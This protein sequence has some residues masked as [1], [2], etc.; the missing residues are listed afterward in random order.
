MVKFNKIEHFRGYR[1]QIIYQQWFRLFAVP[2]PLWRMRCRC[3]PAAHQQYILYGAI[4]YAI[5]KN[6][7][8]IIITS[9]IIHSFY[10]WQNIFT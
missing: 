8:H 3:Y 9:G 5:L 10:L 6:R 2:A 7:F 1:L 4:L